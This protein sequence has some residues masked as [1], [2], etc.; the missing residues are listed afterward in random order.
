MRNILKNTDPDPDP[1][2]LAHPNYK[3]KHNLLQHKGLRI[4]LRT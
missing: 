4:N 2:S 1:A 3:I